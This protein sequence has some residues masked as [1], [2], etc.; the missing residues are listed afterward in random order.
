[1]IEVILQ[2]GY[3]IKQKQKQD[4]LKE[5]VED[6]E[7]VAAALKAAELKKFPIQMQIEKLGRINC[8]RFP[9]DVEKTNIIVKLNQFAFE[10]E[11]FL[12]QQP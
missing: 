11:I 10:L 6:Q 5:M 7:K 2:K 12:I 1:L 4:K 8:D 3:K 9:N